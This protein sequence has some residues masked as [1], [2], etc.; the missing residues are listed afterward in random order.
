MK[1]P[2]L[3]ICNKCK[4]EIRKRIT[5]LKY[6]QDKFYKIKDSDRAFTIQ[7]L[8]YLIGDEVDVIEITPKIRPPRDDIR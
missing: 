2:E 6:L 7:Q 4:I 8:Q 1:C 5:Y 3:K